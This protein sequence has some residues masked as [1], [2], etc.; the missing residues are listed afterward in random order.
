G[1]RLVGAHRNQPHG[2]RPRHEPPRR[3]RRRLHHSQGR[4]HTMKTLQLG[5]LLVLMSTA[6]A[7]GNQL[8][9]FGLDD[10]P[11]NSDDVDAGQPAAGDPPTVITTGPLNTAANV[12]INKKISATFSRMMAPATLNS[13]SFT[14]QRGPTAIAGTVSYTAGTAT[15]APTSTLDVALEYTATITTGATD[16]LGIALASNYIWTFTTGACSQ[17]SIALR[18]AGALAVLAGST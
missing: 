5:T 17:A 15:F 7:C 12:S 16:P 2:R 8:V 1:L 4:Q 11:G 10:E 18:A 3:V 14:V 6:G 9:E 13:A